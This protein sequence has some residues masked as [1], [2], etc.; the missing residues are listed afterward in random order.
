MEF[1]AWEAKKIELESVLGVQ[2]GRI[3]VVASAGGLFPMPYAPIYASAKAGLVNFARSI[4]PSLAEKGIAISAL[5]PQ[6]VDTPMGQMLMKVRPEAMKGATSLISLDLV[7]HAF[8]LPPYL[9]CHPFQHPRSL[10]IVPSFPPFL[11]F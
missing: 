8:L 2:A 1:P 9:R 10:S 6:P 3:V 4:A 11:L 5:C 7:C